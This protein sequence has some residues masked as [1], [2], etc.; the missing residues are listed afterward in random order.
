MNL[1]T[2]KQEWQRVVVCE[3]L[4]PLLLRRSTHSPPISF[5]ALPL[6]H[7]NRRCSDILRSLLRVGRKRDEMKMAGGS[8]SEA[9]VVRIKE[10][11]REDGIRVSGGGDGSRRRQ[12][13]EGGGGRFGKVAAKCFLRVRVTQS[14]R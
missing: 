2:E 5:A 10:R 7:T 13:L 8:V 6:S 12:V 9:L 3:V 11:S 14:E 4:R 1:E